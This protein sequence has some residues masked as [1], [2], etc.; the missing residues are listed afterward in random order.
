MAEDDRNLRLR[1][2]P[3]RG[4]YSVFWKDLSVY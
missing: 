1:A 3:R 4:I 2:G